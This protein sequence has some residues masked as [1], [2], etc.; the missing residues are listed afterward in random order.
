MKRWILEN[1]WL[2]VLAFLIAVV[3]WAYVG[4]RQI[5]ERK[6]TLHLELAD[7]PAGVKVDSN[8]KTAISVVLRGRKESVLDLD[9]GDLNA[10]ISLAGISAGK[11]DLEVRPSIKP[12]PPGVAVNVQPVTLH[13][14]PVVEAAPPSK[15]KRKSRR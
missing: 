9:P 5:L 6:M 10:V 2:K 15:S 7:V 14:V 3:L 4:T 1:F 13:L 12:L 8:V 11:K